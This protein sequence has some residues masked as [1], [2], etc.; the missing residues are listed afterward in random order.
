MLLALALAAVA[1]DAPKEPLAPAV[2]VW[3]E[4]ALPGIDALGR[5]ARLTG[6]TPTHR[7]WSDLALAE[8][9]WTEEDRTRVLAVQT[10][11]DTARKRW[12]DFDVELGIAQQV[13]IAVDNV[14]VV[15][16][17]DDRKALVDALVLGGLAVT[18]AWPEARFPSADDAAPHRTLVAARAMPRAWVDALALEPERA[19][20]R[21]EVDDALGLALLETLKRELAA[22]PPAKLEIPELP[23]GVELVVD[24]RP[25]PAGTAEVTLPPG[26][27]YVHARVGG[28]VAGR[29]EFV[30]ESGQVRRYPLRVDRAQLDAARTAALAGATDL[31]PELT[32]ALQTVSTVKGQPA[33][34]YLASL[35]EKGRPEVVA[36]SGGAELIRPKPVTFVL[37]GDIGPAVVLGEGFASGSATAP[38]F[39][40]NL[41]AELGIYNFAVLGGATLYVT[42]TERLLQQNGTETPMAVRPYGGMGVYLPR[43]RGGAANVLL[44]ATYGAFLP[45]SSGFGALLGVGI[46]VSASGTWVRLSADVYSGTQQE[47][48]A[49]AGTATRAAMFRVGFARKL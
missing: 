40:G 22:L 39:G 31:P 36:W 30:V 12:N 16:D 32:G 6:G 11:S 46:P 43:P 5:A 34:V 2:V 18:R 7:A 15:R 38:G 23:P 24:G 3:L 14:T 47:G 42:P 44:G 1:A 20:T 28:L 13:A 8:N 41:G 21:A 33:R 49:G 27:H 37:A 25:V 35:D 45:G 26:R 48:F 10:A 4:P 29:D 19:W 9:D 17:D